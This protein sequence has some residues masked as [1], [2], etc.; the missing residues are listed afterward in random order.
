MKENQVILKRQKYSTWFKLDEVRPLAFFVILACLLGWMPYIV[1]AL[2]AAD[3]AAALG[4]TNGSPANLPFGP[5]VAAAIVSAFLGRAGLK[6]GWRRLTTFRTARSWYILAF[7]APV[8]IVS[9]AV[10][11]NSAFGAPLPTA[12]QLSKWTD[13]PGL[14]VVYLIVVGIGEEVGWTAFAAPLV[15]SHHKFINAWLI[16][17]A[18]RVFWHLPSC[19]PANCRGPWASAGTSR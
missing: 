9:A 18:I 12:S 8:V 15:L 14:F 13:L 17:A 10:L 3:I 2:G 7:V 19:L 16:L 6:N 1:S 11:A 4:G 5:L